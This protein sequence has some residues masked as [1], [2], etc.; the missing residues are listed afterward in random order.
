MM[1]NN[2]KL[3]FVAQN[4][5]VNFSKKRIVIWFGQCSETHKSCLGSFPCDVSL[6]TLTGSFTVAFNIGTGE[7]VIGA[8]WQIYSLL[9]GNL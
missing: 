4:S 6:K 2:C 7:L 3:T 1:S 9:Q 8:T 5:L